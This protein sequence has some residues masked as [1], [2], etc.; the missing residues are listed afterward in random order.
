M[1]MAKMQKTAVF[2]QFLFKITWP[3]LAIIKVAGK[4]KLL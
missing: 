2:F 3:F 4:F 1:I